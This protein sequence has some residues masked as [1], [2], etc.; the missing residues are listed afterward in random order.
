MSQLCHLRNG[1][2]LKICISQYNFEFNV[3][4]LLGRSLAGK[5]IPFCLYQIIY[6]SHGKDIKRL[7]NKKIRFYITLFD[8]SRCN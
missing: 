1:Q 7:L 5:I 3:F 4:I 2:L 8:A 6:T